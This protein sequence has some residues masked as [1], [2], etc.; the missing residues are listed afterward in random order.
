MFKRRHW[1]WDRYFLVYRPV[2]SIHQTGTQSR[3]CED[4]ISSTH[5]L[6]G[7]F[8][9]ALIFRALIIR[10]NSAEAVVSSPSGCSRWRPHSNWQYAV[11]IRADGWRHLLYFPTG[12][13]PHPPAACCL[14]MHRA[15][16]GLSLTEET[17][18]RCWP[19]PDSDWATD[20]RSQDRSSILGSQRRSVAKAASLRPLARGPVSIPDQSLWDLWRTIWHCDS[21]LSR[22][23]SFLDRGHPVVFKV[24]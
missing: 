8:L 19:S 11:G 2:L 22:Y 16:A 21:F 10:T 23:S 13:V 9:C 15:A 3:N 20:W 4:V 24:N 12:T 6:A 7:A 14:C 17:E 18:S 1:T 5:R